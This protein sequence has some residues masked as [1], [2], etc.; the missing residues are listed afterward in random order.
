[1]ISERMA[2]YIPKKNLREYENKLKDGDIV[3][4]TTHIDGLDVMH[5]GFVVWINNRVRL[6]HASSREEKVIISE[7]TLEDYLQSN[8]SATGIMVA[9]MF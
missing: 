1:M 6:L 3:A 5:V 2:W 4:I 7:E 9:R 8:K